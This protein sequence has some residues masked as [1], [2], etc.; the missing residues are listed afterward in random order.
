MGASATQWRREELCESSSSWYTRHLDLVP[1]LTKL[2]FIYKR[3]GS[4]KHLRTTCIFA[5]IYVILGNLSGNAIAFGT[6]VLEAAGIEGHHSAVRGLAVACLTAACLLHASWR[7]GGI[8]V[9][10]LLALLKVLIL[11]AVIGIGFAA[12]AGAS[13]GH[14]PVHGET[15]DPTSGKATPN[16]NTHTSFAH[17]RKDTASYADSILFIIYTFSGYEQP[18]YVSQFLSEHSSLQN[19]MDRSGQNLT[20]AWNQVLSEVHQPKKKFAKSTIGAMSLVGVLFVLVN[21]AYVRSS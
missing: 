17:A 4:K 8:F 6:Y 16:F 2:E 13:F 5:V 9:N 20:L 3:A 18:F 1:D 14:G 10:N 7:K 15:I 21:V 11:L 19:E 12:S